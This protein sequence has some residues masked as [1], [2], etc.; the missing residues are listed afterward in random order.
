MVGAGRRARGAI[1]AVVVYGLVPDDRAM[2]A[3]IGGEGLGQRTEL[4][5]IRVAAA[6]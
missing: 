5:V 6:L 4:T 2:R 3:Y 1:V